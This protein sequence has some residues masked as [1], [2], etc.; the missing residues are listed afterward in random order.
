MLDFAVTK[1]FGQVAGDVTG[2]II[3]QLKSFS[4]GEFE[5]FFWF[6]PTP[7]KAGWLGSI[8]VSRIA[9]VTFVPARSSA[10]GATARVPQEAPVS[11]AFCS[12][13]VASEV[14]ATSG[15]TSEIGTERDD[16]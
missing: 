15:L 6:K 4:F 10:F 9:T 12:P 1:P 16:A 8:P 13:S 7:L 2:A 5:K 11:L 14:S 3:G